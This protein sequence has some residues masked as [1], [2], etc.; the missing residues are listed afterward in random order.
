MNS[1]I[2]MLLLVFSCRSSVMDLHYKA[3]D[4]DYARYNMKQDK[5]ELFVKYLPLLS[6]SDKGI[7][8]QEVSESK[9][10]DEKMKYALCLLE[11]NCSLNNDAL[12]DPKIKEAA[13]NIAHYAAFKDAVINEEDLVFNY[14]VEKTSVF[15]DLVEGKPRF[16]S[17]L[18]DMKPHFFK[19][20]MDIKP[21][22]LT[23]DLAEEIIKLNSENGLFLPI[24]NILKIFSVKDNGSD[25][26]N[27]EEQIRQD[28]NFTKSL[29]YYLSTLE[30]NGEAVQSFDSDLETVILEQDIDQISY[31][32]LLPYFSFVSSNE[33]LSKTEKLRIAYEKK[34]F[35][36]YK[37]QIKDN[38]E[39]MA[40]VLRDILVSKDEEYL[41][42]LL[43]SLKDLF[44]QVLDSKELISSFL[45]L[46]LQDNL[47]KVIVYEW[48]HNKKNIYREKIRSA[49]GN[50]IVSYVLLTKDVEASLKILD[51]ASDTLKETLQEKNDEDKTPINLCFEIFKDSEDSL[52]QV[53]D[54]ILNLTFDVKIAAAISSYTHELTSDSQLRISQM[55]GTYYMK[56]SNSMSNNLMPLNGD[57]VPPPAYDATDYTGGSNEK[58]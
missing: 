47:R 25:K 1:L 28:N 45:N 21:H 31:A 38:A 5:Y 33:S 41:D 9:Q 36:L 7:L 27:L 44:L 51:E 43:A 50:N 17:L 54:R 12:L 42:F 32:P 13:D 6:E 55:L 14:I 3:S 46:F 18:N 8:L 24:P 39:E 29:T 35:G 58:S 23:C 34:Y 49:Q 40:E 37:H 20:M 4:L 56:L 11:S 15:E 53:V 48:S 19:K 26:F 22:L 2:A 16:F 52:L 10:G 57:D 30:S